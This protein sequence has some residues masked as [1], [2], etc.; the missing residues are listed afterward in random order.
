[1][2]VPGDRTLRILLA[3]VGLTREG[4]SPAKVPFEDASAK[5]HVAV[6]VSQSPI[7]I[8]RTALVIGP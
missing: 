5:P 4:T 7:P 2:V 1:M 6:N 8:T 3:A